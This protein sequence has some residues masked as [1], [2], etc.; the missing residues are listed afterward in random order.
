[1]DRTKR[2]GRRRSEK[3]SEMGGSESKA[4]VLECMIKNFKGFGEDCGVKMTPNRL[5]IVC[6]V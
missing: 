1:M 2:E 6:E 3:V 5:C 4:I